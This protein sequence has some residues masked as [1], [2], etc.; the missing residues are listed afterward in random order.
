MDF[1]FTDDQEQ[2]RDAVR[3]WVDKGYT[4]ERRR[5]IVKAGGFSRGAFTELA[6]L[7]LCG[8]YIAEDGGGMG[9]GPVDAM[10]VMEELGRGI[11]L[12]PLAQSLIAGGVLSGYAQSALKS[13]WLPR[14][15]S[16]EAL[17]VLAHQER[18]ARY[19]LD[20]CEATAAQASS[21]WTVSATKNMVP[22]GDQ[23]DAFLVPAQ[24]K[25]KIALFL[26]ERSAK[27]VSTLGYGTQDGGRAA[28]LTLV[29]T[30]AQLITLDGLSAL[31]H[32]VDIGI[33]SLCAEAVGVMD[34]TLAATLEYMNTRKQFGVLIGSFQALR[35]R[36]TD[37]KMQL[38][39]A[40]SMSYYAS[41]KLNAPTEERR[42]AMARAKVQ[43]GQSMRFVG[44]QAVQLHGGIGVTDELIISHYFK[45][46]T[47]LEMTFGDN[48]HHLG[49][50][51]ARMQD[52]AGVFA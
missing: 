33:A 23:A 35:H 36:A 31:E 7:G 30:A 41:L 47:Q 18:K 42:R 46:L 24:V 27:G 21:G 37:M 13:G 32:A 26:V 2:L 38:E 16:G 6:E 9:M 8:L 14:I 51:S 4:F 17:V 34:K 10:V 3:K 40:R 1:D 11:V 29:N 48:L 45:K 5:S 43:L 28:D 39:L 15:A 22:V 52:S 20:A 50:V 44:Q 19:R 12:E 25:G 49:E